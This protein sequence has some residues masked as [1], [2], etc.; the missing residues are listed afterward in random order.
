MRRFS[1]TLS[2]AKRPRPSGTCA[3]PARATESAR[4]RE[5][6][7]PAKATPPV[8]RTSPDTARNVVVLPAPFAP[9]NA[10]ISPSSTWSDT[11]CSA[12]IGPY[13]AS[14]LLSSSSGGI[15]RSQVC[16]D[17]LGVRLYLC[18]RP[19]CDR[20]PEVEHVDTVADRHH[21]VHVVLDEQHGQVEVLA[22]LA[23]HI[24]E[25]SD[26]LVVQPAGRLVEQ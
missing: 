23:D 16:L 21:E 10:T 3:T 6:C 19:V 17:H 22:H 14:T 12:L 9:S 26:I 2:S 15:V 7:L 13:R 4:A 20:A 1:Q 8:W 25:L 5:S 11:P 18:R 24:R